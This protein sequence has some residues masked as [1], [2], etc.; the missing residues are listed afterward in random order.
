MSEI[1][2]TDWVGYLAM[3]LVISSFIFKNLIKLRMVNLAGAFAFITY[4]FMLNAMPII[5]TNSIIIVIQIYHL[6]KPKF[7]TNEPINN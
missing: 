7:T 2:M 1:T 3:I 4:G 5:I 6:V